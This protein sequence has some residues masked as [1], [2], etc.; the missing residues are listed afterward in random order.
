MQKKAAKQNIWTKEAWD[1]RQN[2]D[3]KTQQTKRKK[4]GL[5]YISCKQQAQEEKSEGN[6]KPE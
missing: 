4:T 5:E 6:R 3:S 2:L 1:R